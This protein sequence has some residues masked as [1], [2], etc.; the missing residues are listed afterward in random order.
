MYS[1]KELSMSD[2]AVKQERLQE[3]LQTFQQADVN[4]DGV[5]DFAE[6]T[7]FMNEM[8]RLSNAREVPAMSESD[9]NDDIKQ[10]VWDFFNSQGE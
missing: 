1:D 2:E 6:L 4:G 3:M 10:K 7:T 9:V 5:L 8:G